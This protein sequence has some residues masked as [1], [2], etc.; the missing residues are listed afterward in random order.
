VSDLA[1]LVV[2]ELER[3][4]ALLERVARVLDPYLSHAA[5]DGWFG[6]RRAA[7]YI[8]AGSLDAL[9]RLVDNGLPCVQPHGPGGRRYFRRRDLDR[10]MLD[11]AV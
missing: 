3:D 9:D 4:P 5:N 8:G 10:Y 2:D 1:R 11:A 6:A 7:D